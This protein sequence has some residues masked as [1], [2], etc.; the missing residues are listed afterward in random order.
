[1]RKTLL[2]LL[3]ILI[4]ISIIVAVFYFYGFNKTLEVVRNIYL[5]YFFIGFFFYIIR[6]LMGTWRMQI[7]LENFEYNISFLSVFKAHMGG[8]IT[9]EFTPS[10]TG[11][12]YAS[13]ILKRND[14]IP[15]EVGLSSVISSNVLEFTFKVV[16]VFLGIIY[17][18]WV[19]KPLFSIEVYVLLVFIALLMLIITIILILALWWE[20]ASNI[21]PIF[22]KVP[23]LNTVLKK[24][25]EVQS[26]SKKIK[27]ILWKIIVISLIIWGIKG[28]TWLFFFFSLGI[29]EISYFECMLLQPLVSAF[30]FIPLF[31]SGIGIQEI[32][33]IFI[34]GIFNISPPQAIAYDILLRSMFLFNLLGI[35]FVLSVIKSSNAK[36][37]M[38]QKKLMEE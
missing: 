35:F 3:Q 21:I 24:I 34:L 23:Y 20:K 30:S 4:G 31:P 12:F 28:I 13:L 17:L 36:D 26:E 8:I 5:P 37:E 25:K 33:I 2:N 1:L 15:F 16:G 38:I 7:I 10:R 27:P 18:I 9:S 32:G 19:L 11:Y 6:N 22:E 29:Y 14:N